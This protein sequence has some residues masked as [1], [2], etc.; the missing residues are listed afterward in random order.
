MEKL[1][2]LKAFADSIGVNSTALCGD[3]IDQ[4]AIDRFLSEAKKAGKGEI[5]SYMVLRCMMKAKYDPEAAPHFGLGAKCYCHFTSPI[6]RYPDLVVHRIIKTLLLH[7]NAGKDRQ[8]R[9]YAYKAAER[10]NDCEDTATKLERDMD[11]LYMA[12]FMQDKIG[13]KYDAVITGVT[14][15]GFFARTAFGAGGL[16]RGGLGGRRGLVGEHGKREERAAADNQ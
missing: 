6:R 1:K 14:Q 9:S 10:S 16:G 3:V 4:A 13:Q 5:L 8:L 12:S 2:A 7:D 15:Y 11:D